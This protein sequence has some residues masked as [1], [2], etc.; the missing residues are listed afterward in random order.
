MNPDRPS[1]ERKEKPE[2][3]YHGSSMPDIETFELR[4]NRVPAG[5]MDAPARIYAGDIPSFAAAFSFRWGAN[6][7]YELSVEK[8]NIVF[9]VPSKFKDRLMHKVYLYK[10]PSDKFELTEGEGT[11]HSYHAQESL[12]PT[13]VQEFSSVQDAIEHF[14]GKVIYIES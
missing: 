10:V 12:K 11:G 1:L 8:D 9:K 7:G 14:G 2:F 5:H 4:N 6:E 3:L 13:E